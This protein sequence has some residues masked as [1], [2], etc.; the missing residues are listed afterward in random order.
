MSA[1]TRAWSVHILTASGLIFALLAAIEICVPQP[2]ARRVFLWL[3]IAV[4]I[5]AVDGPLARRFNVKVVLPQIDGRKID[6][7]VDYLTFTFLPLL[8]IAR[9]GWVPAPVLLYV[10]PPMIAS[11]LAFANAGAKD[12]VRGFFLGFPSYWNVVALYAGIVAASIGTWPNAI[13]LLALAVLTVSPVGFIYPNLA[14]RRWKGVIMIGA[15]VWAAMLLAML[16]QYP[17][18][19]LWLVVLSLVY[20]V[21]YTGISLREYFGQ[22]KSAGGNTGAPKSA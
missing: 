4:V 8:L 20:P 9:M 2:D 17:E 19:A 10:V 18:P 15:V 16:P 14:P 3:F 6:D 12:E 1:Q 5:D 21:L 7:I 22:T 11:V 13:A